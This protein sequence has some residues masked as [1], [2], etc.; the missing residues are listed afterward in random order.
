M[1][2]ISRVRA[3]LGVEVAIRGLFEAPT[4]EGLAKS[5]TKN[6]QPQDALKIL[7]TL[8]AHG[9]LPPLFCIHPAAGISWSYATLVRHI[10]IDYPVYGLQARAILQPHTSPQTL[11]EMAGDYVEQI[12]RIQPAGPYQLLG[13]SFGG[14]VAHAIATHLQNIGQ[15]V[16]LIALLDTYPNDRKNLLRRGVDNSE[17]EDH[18]TGY[19]DHPLDPLRHEGQILSTLE[20]HH[21][22]TIKN[23]FNDSGR[24]MK[25][26]LPQQFHGDVLLFVATDDETKPAPESW[27]PYVSGQIKVF[28]IGCTHVKMMTDPVSATKIGTVLATELDR[29]RTP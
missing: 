10:P 11:E 9:S 13:W 7:L 22:E 14:L 3:T 18:F 15:Q 21:Y 8:R 4:I 12:R 29:L 28:R 23:A 17:K 5:L 26:F 2:L 20:N 16:A 6:H 24:L 19:G 1:R 27:R 25:T